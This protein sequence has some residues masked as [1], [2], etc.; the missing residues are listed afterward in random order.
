M[1][2]HS[3]VRSSD[4]FVEEMHEEILLYKAGSHKAIYLNES[5]ALVWKL[6]DGTKTVQDIADILSE[7]FP[8]TGADLAHEIEQAVEM[9]LREGAVSA[10]A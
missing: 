3:L 5:A 10:K 4:F 9:L 6:C 8:D 7:N 1:K 2:A